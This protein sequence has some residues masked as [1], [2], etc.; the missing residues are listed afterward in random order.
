MHI[1]IYMHICLFLGLEI[2]SGVPSKS[3]LFLELCLL[4]VFGWFA[5][6]VSNNC[7]LSFCHKQA[8]L[9]VCLLGSSWF[10]IPCFVVFAHP[11]EILTEVCFTV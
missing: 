9:L 3:L 7:P 6:L 10:L 2:A 5:A 4:V 1:Y 11:S 8:W